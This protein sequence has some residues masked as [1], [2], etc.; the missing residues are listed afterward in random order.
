VNSVVLINSTF[1]LFTMSQSKEN[2]QRLDEIINSLRS[3]SLHSSDEIKNLTES[4]KE[5]AVEVRLVEAQLILGDMLIAGLQVDK[6]EIMAFSMYMMAAQQN[7]AD[8]QYKVASMYESGKGVS[9]NDVEALRWY[10]EAAYQGHPDA[11]FNIG[12]RYI[13]GRGLSQSYVEAARWI[14]QSARMDAFDTSSSS[15]EEE[16]IE[17]WEQQQSI[18]MAASASA[19]AAAARPMDIDM[20]ESIITEEMHRISLRNIQ[21]SSFTSSSISAAVAAPNPRTTLPPRTRTTRRSN[22]DEQSTRL[23]TCLTAEGTLRT[24]RVYSTFDLD[25]LDSDEDIY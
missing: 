23:C 10:F 22:V 1:L 17:L 18:I 21:P 20:V 9:L 7:E 8:A 2:Y 5:L 3:S 15:S 16:M 14:S 6:D 12:R 24:M 13:E 11:M 19:A 25:E 4:L